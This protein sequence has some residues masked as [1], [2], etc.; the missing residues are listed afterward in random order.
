MFDAS[1]GLTAA[2][3]ATGRA[4]VTANSSFGGWGLSTDHVWPSDARRIIGQYRPEV[5]V[6]TWS[7]DDGLAAGNPRAYEMR[8]E[9]AVRILLTPGDG[10]DL[11]VLLEYPPG[12]P[13]AAVS[14]PVVQA[15]RWNDQLRV[16]A[17][18]DRVARSVT[19]A[20]PGHAAYLRTAPVFAPGNRFMTWMRV[21]GGGWIR[22]RKLDN[23]HMCP[24]G[25]A[26]FG[27][28]IVNALRE[29][30]QLG[31]MAPGW[32][33]GSWIHEGRYNDP[34][35]ACPADQPPAGYT[36]VPLPVTSR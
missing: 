24:Y 27:S 7:W 31:A 20:F 8:L 13:A 10:V 33:T 1:S 22:A 30:L 32:E 36:G 29:P 21:P 3:E 9:Q 35:G 2:L 16:Q 15:A 23:T 6:G 26:L 19:A 18:W 11:V 17:A 12:G 14:D 28:A 4:T 34:P 5:V 25:A